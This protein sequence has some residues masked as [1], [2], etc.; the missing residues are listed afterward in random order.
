MSRNLDHPGGTEESLNQG[1]PVGGMEDLI[2][3]C[4]GDNACRLG[5]GSCRVH[6]LILAQAS[7]ILQDALA[8]TRVKDAD[9]VSQ[10]KVGN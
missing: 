7:P 1:C 10:L 5:A 3:H 2:L 8:L 6:S 9:G 4:S